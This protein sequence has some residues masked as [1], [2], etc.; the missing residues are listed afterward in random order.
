[1]LDQCGDVTIEKAFSQFA[2]HGVLDI[3]LG[4]GGLVVVLPRLGGARRV[5][6]PRRSSRDSIVATV[7]WASPRSGCR[8]SQMSWT[9][10]SPRSQRTRRMASWSSVNWCRSGIF[11]PRE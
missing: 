6:T 2:D 3:L 1:M 10:A 8:A 5:T 9:V 11:W 4:H 7:V